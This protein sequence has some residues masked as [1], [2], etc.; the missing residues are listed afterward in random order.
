V[1]NIT[2]K[3]RTATAGA[4]QATIARFWKE[5]SAGGKVG[6]LISGRQAIVV[7]SALPGDPDPLRGGLFF[8]L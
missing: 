5:I 6:F 2:P 7:G 4:Q 8:V 1:P 3:C